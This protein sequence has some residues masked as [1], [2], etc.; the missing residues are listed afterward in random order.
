MIENIKK[1]M[2]GAIGAGLVLVFLPAVGLFVGLKYFEANLTA[3]L[4]VMAIFG[5]MILLGSMALT[6]TLFHRLAL[7]NPNEALGLP[8]GSIRAALSLALVVL[9]AIISIMLFRSLASPA[10]KHFENV[11]QSF[12]EE[13]AKR[14]D[15]Q[16]VAL[17]SC[18]KVSDGVT[19]TCFNVVVRWK[20]PNDAV[21]ISKQLLT[22]IGTLMTSLTSY[23][24]ATRAAQ[25]ARNGS[26]DGSTAEPKPSST[27]KPEQQPEPAV[28]TAVMLANA[29]DQDSDGCDAE[30]LEPTK[31]EDLP[32][33]KGGVA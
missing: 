12:I 23:Y 10:E 33:A 17:S 26:S 14:P 3:G 16:V 18:Q 28:Q 20:A 15:A 24:F 9:F 2:D 5:I 4:P 22:L 8:A 19:A 1:L 31:D 7:S 13:L 21:D 25:T 27:D 32:P 30:I 29:G 6:S 11:G